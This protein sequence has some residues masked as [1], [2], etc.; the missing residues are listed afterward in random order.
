MILCS[1]IRRLNIVKILNLLNWSKDSNQNSISLFIETDKLIIKIHIILTPYQIKS[2][3]IFFSH[4]VDCLF[5]L[6]FPFIY[7]SFLLWCH[8]TCLFLLLLPVFW[9][10][11]KKKNHCHDFS[12]FS[13]RHLIVSS[14]PFKFLIHFK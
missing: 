1:W 6:L 4:S 12:L 11:I 2:L 10:H 14:F 3:Q 8:P 9:C 7:R 5:I 13:Y